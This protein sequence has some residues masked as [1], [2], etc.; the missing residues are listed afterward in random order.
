MRR[1]EE[2]IPKRLDRGEGEDEEGKEAAGEVEVGEESGE[3]AGEGGVVIQDEV[4]VGVF[5][6]SGRSG[7][8][9][10]GVQRRARSKASSFVKAERFRGRDRS[11]DDAGL[12]F[13]SKGERETVH[14][15]P[16]AG[17]II[18]LAGPYLNI[19]TLFRRSSNLRFIV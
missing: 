15:G 5:S 14:R 11:G 19:L 12:P 10:E 16:M 8:G 3:G 4:G 2:E 7:V 6:F 1:G 18:H 9:L 13:A 17:W